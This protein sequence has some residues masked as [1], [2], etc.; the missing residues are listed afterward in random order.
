MKL[1]EER[2]RIHAEFVTFLGMIE[3]SKKAICDI[4]NLTSKLTFGAFY[5][6]LS[7]KVEPF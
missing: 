2:N 5:L 3:S 6:R 1:T 7:G 4:T